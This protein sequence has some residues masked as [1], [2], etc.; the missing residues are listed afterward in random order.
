[1]LG[2][3]INQLDPG[4]IIDTE[5]FLASLRKEFSSICERSISQG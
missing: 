5:Q 1:M 3:D 2:A 4:C